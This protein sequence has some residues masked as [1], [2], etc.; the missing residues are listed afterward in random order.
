ME[1]TDP[2]LPMQQLSRPSSFPVSSID[3]PETQSALNGSTHALEPYR[4][5]SSPVQSYSATE[6]PNSPQPWELE[7]KVNS[8]PS[9]GPRKKKLLLG[10]VAVLAII[11]AVV[12][13]CVYF[14]A[15]RPKNT[16]NRAANA[17]DPGGPATRS[18]A[19]PGSSGQP[20]TPTSKAQ[21]TTGG[22]GSLITMEDGT[23][24]VY[25]NTFGGY[26]VDDP[27][28]PF[29]SGARPQ[30]WSPALN[31]TFRYGIDRIRG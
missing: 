2:G 11:L 13:L 4:D 1:A 23:T 28:D 9:R 6:V 29:N 25:R 20:P 10:V 14:L 19:N 26:W 21:Q 31:E 17:N 3:Y 22:D 7:S 30:S 15:I 27:N 16:S 24:F 18:S 5:A 12:M 8:P